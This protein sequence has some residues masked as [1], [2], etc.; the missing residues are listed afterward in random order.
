LSAVSERAEAAQSDAQE[1]RAAIAEARA[2]VSANLVAAVTARTIKIDNGLA[3][4]QAAVA[5]HQTTLAQRQ[6]QVTDLANMLLRTINLAV[7][8]LTVLFLVFAAGQVL[9][10]YICWQYVRTGRFP[11]LRVARG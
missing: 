5:K 4:I 8:L 3:Q 1:L 9:L 2:G 6:Q 11:S 10:I 7:V